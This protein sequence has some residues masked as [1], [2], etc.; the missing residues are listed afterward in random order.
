MTKPRYPPF[1]G[2]GASSKCNDYC[3]RVASLLFLGIGVVLTGAGVLSFIS[4][5]TFTELPMVLP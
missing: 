3:S 1:K 2:N 4:L 5:V